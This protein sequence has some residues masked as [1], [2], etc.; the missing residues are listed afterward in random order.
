MKDALSISR[1]SLPVHYSVK[2]SHYKKWV[3]LGTAATQ[4]NIGAPETQIL[5]ANAVLIFKHLCS[6]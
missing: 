4:R 1:L 5:L 2:F 6:I 3:G